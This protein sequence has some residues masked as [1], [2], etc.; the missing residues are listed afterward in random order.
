MSLLLILAF[1]VLAVIGQAINVTI[2]MQVDPYSETASLAVFF[3]LLLVLLYLAWKLA[4]RFTAPAAER[5][6]V[7]QPPA[8]RAA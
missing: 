5:H 2:A 6:Q 4:V 7:K 8:R 3:T 1:I